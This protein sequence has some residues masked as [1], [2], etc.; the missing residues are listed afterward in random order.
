MLNQVVL[1][2]KVSEKYESENMTLEVERSFKNIFGVYEKDLIPVK[3][4]HNILIEELEVGS[5]IAIKGRLEV[6]DNS[7]SVVADRVT[8]LKKEVA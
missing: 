4:F 8:L 6:K 5:V 2:G 3:V 7:M 1:V